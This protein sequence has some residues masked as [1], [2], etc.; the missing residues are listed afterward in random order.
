MSSSARCARSSTTPGASGATIT[1]ATLTDIGRLFF[2]ASFRR[3]AL[4]QLS[5]PLL[6]GTW[7]SYEAMSAPEQAA[8]V[9]AAL[10]KVSS[11]IGRPRVRAILAQPEPKLD[12][13]RL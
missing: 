13:G 9:Q 5:D 2:D 4:E 11:L 3:Q 6:V 1:G 7:Q 10:T 8:H 12:I